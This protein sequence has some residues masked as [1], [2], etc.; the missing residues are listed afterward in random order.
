M[1]K[2]TSQIALIQHRRGN[3]SELP[4]QL[5]EGE[6]A[7]ATDTN[8]IFMGNPNNP[9]LQERVNRAEPVFP[10]GNIHLLTEFTDNMKYFRYSLK[11]NDTTVKF[12]ITVMA[13]NQNPILKKGSS[14]FINGTELVFGKETSV[15]NDFDYLVI[16]YIWTD[17]RDL[18]T[19]T[20][21]VNADSLPDINNIGLGYNYPDDG[22]LGQQRGVVPVDATME[23]SVLYW[24]RD[25]TGQATPDTPMEENILISRKTLDSEDYFEALPDILKIQLRAMWYNS[26]GENPV[27][28]EIVAYKNGVMKR[29]DITYSF[30]NEGGERI[31]FIDANG[32]EKDSL[33]LVV[34]NMPLVVKKYAL[35]GNLYINKHTK[36]SYLTLENAPTEEEPEVYYI[37]DIV[38]KINEANINVKAINDNGYLKLITTEN[39][40][41]I[42]DGVIVD[43]ITNMSILGFDETSFVA[44]PPIKRTLQDVLDDRVS[45]KNF[46]I[47]S[48]GNDNGTKIHDSFISMY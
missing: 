4:Y 45:I 17:G 24:G 2:N 35:I 46:N 32:D 19:D 22:D 25:N 40:L 21:I 10:Y 42:Q 5:N 26:I 8:D 27:Q 11:M 12:P 39:S 47:D 18:D 6:F 30:Y 1:T 15:I 33:L 16:R 43:N 34:K 31:K 23:N 38:K 7:L 28:I 13:K 37:S 48:N 36:Q 41:T 14:I 9:I 29:D 3:L 20:R 44:I